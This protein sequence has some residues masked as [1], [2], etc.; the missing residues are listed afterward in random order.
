MWCSTRLS[1]PLRCGSARRSLH[2]PLL[3]AT[4]IP[5]RLFSTTVI[6]GQ[7]ESAKIDPVTGLKASEEKDK[8]FYVT[9]PI[10]YVNAAPHVGHMYTMVLVD[11][12]KRWEQLK[13]R[14][15]LLVTGTDEH[16]MKIQQAAQLAQKDPLEF[17]DTGAAMFQDLAARVNC[18][19]DTFIRTTDPKHH[20]AVQYFWQMLQA[21][22]LIYSDKH[23]GW[24]SVA[25]ETF[26]PENSVESVVDP[27]TG[28]KIKVS[29]ETG[30][31]VQ[32][33]SEVN[34]H[35][36]L[37]SMAPKL[38]EFYKQNPDWI[39][40]HSRYKEVVAAVE[41]GLEDLSISRTRS[42]LSW[43]IQVPNDPEQTV[44][45][46]LD[47]LVNY[48][49]ASGYPWTPGREQALGWPADLHVIGK[50]IVKF[51]CIYWPAFLLAL[52]LPMP[53]R[54]LTHAHWTMNHKKMSKSD[55]N[56]VNPFYAIDRFGTDP[57]RYYMA[58][59]GGIKDDGDYSNEMILTRYRSELQRGFGNITGR[60]RG[61]KFDVEASV[62]AAMSGGMTGDWIFDTVDVSM[63]KALDKHPRDVYD[64][65]EKLDIPG[66][67]RG[68]VDL[69]DET[70]RYLQ[71]TAPWSI[72]KEKNP[73]ELLR[74]IYFAAEAIRICAI[75]L[76]PFMPEKAKMILDN[77]SVD[78]AK[79]TMHHAAIAMD[80][81]YGARIGKPPQPFPPLPE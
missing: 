8:P 33:T 72:D 63:V 5:A 45:V 74:R 60:V 80:D 10:F 79:R 13:G 58:R 32:W 71:D 35:F 16:G 12:V 24:Y 43:G 48:L 38:L 30:R 46:W 21:R 66:G 69:M 31:E 14:K 57:M 67:L 29:K 42:R 19:Y 49:T 2:A 50:D 22:D 40:P 47:A 26:Y 23:S 59:D 17:C 3:S 15:A 41:E 39:V 44:Y 77:F 76:Q 55:G 81:A 20:D 65:M 70:N 56:V 51:H 73:T 9:S 37:S 68:I 36:R 28:Q 64:R 78:P 4:R 11:V 61:K 7:Q 53:K 52:D 18:K 54:I 27:A 62:K 25:D 34:Y 1:P 75:L 6:R